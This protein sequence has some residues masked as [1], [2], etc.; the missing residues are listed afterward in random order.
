[1]TNQ[2]LSRA[3]VYAAELVALVELKEAEIARLNKGSRASLS[4]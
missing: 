4:I 2:Q 3:N 1:M